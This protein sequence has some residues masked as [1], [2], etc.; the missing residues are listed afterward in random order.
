[1][2]IRQTWLCQNMV[3][4]MIQNKDKVFDWADAWVF[5]SMKRASNDSGVVDFSLLVGVG[6][7]LN[8]A[9]FND[10]EIRTAIQK[11]YRYGLVDLVDHKIIPTVIAQNLFSRVD[12]KRGGLFAVV[13][14]CLSVLNSP[15]TELVISKGKSADL[16]FLSSDFIKKTTTSTYAVSMSHEIRDSNKLHGGYR[17]LHH[18]TTSSITP[19]PSRRALSLITSGGQIFTAPPPTPTGA[20]S[21]T[22]RL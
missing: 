16:D 10:S 13:D 11:F 3:R 8:H 14:N 9:I 19:R 15:K 21:I 20:K 22:P 18:R 7:V 2:A 1:M 12:Q 4:I 6:D 5:A 17:V